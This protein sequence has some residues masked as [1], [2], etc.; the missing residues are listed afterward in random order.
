MLHA[1]DAKNDRNYKAIRRMRD[2]EKDADTEKRK[3]KI[4]IY[5]NRSRTRNG[6]RDRET[7]QHTERTT[8]ER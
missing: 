8:R 1:G 5:R 4:K 6:K 3:F 7:K 2:N